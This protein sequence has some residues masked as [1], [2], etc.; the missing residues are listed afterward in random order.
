MS[1]MEERFADV[2]STTQHSPFR[3]PSDLS[4]AASFAQHYALATGRAVLGDIAN[5][6]VNVESGRLGWHLDRIRL[7]GRFDT[8]CINET[9]RDGADHAEREQQITDFFDDMLPIAAP[10]ER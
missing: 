1:E 7:D 5:E 4:T 10:W 8:Y 6:Y 3:S 2:V 9:H